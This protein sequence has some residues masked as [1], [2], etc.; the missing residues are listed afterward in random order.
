M[1]CQDLFTLK[2]EKIIIVK[3]KKKKNVAIEIASRKVKYSN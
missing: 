3:K 2:S 1:K